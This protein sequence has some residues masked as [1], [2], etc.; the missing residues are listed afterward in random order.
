[1]YVKY[2]NSH[3]ASPVIDTLDY[4]CKVI[5]LCYFVTFLSKFC[6]GSCQIN[7][8]M[9]MKCSSRHT[10]A[11]IDSIFGGPTPSNCTP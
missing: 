9:G 5:I 4:T 2:S 6:L 10:L 11:P 1:M 3:F 7:I 8:V